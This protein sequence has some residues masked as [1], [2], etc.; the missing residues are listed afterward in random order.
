MKLIILLILCG[1]ILFYPFSLYEKGVSFFSQEPEY[2]FFSQ[3]E[4]IF[5]NKDKKN[6]FL[7]LFFS[8]NERKKFKELHVCLF[9]KEI[10]HRNQKVL[11]A[12]PNRLK[13]FFDTGCAKRS[14]TVRFTIH[15]MWKNYLYKS[16]DGKK[17]CKE[18]NNCGTLIEDDDKHMVIGWDRFSAEVFVKK[19]NEYKSVPIT[20]DLAQKDENLKEDKLKGFV[21]IQIPSGGIGNQLFGYWSGVIYALKNNKK[22]LFYQKSYIENHLILP[23]KTSEKVKFN[24]GAQPGYV[25]KHV[26][27]FVSNGSSHH[28]INEKGNFIYLNGYSQSWRNFTGYEDY[29]REHTVFKHPMLA[30]SKEIAQKMQ[31]ENSVSIHVRRGDY[32]WQGYILLT[33]KYYTQA[34]EYMKANLDNP[35]FY[36]FSN[37]MKWVRE[38]LKIDAPHTFVDWNKKDYQDLEL[39]SFCKNHIIANS[40]FSWWGAFLSKNK[41]KIIIAPDKHASW[42][43]D[44]FKSLLAPDFVVLDVDFH[45][46]DRK[47]NDFVT[48]K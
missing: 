23:Y 18:S 4:S 37:D 19:N 36:I 28:T 21:E 11:F 8:E 47:K 3:Q 24:Y 25:K 44:W 27:N 7:S 31:Q 38:N 46:W 14:D 48:K 13:R 45:Y 39:M 42:T 35:H 6:K 20:F 9:Q 41:N 26:E 32:V 12:E 43:G 34:I 29:I 1:Y 5:N 2:F 17:I 16:F 30:K 10:L 33:Q 15:K 22:P 40:T